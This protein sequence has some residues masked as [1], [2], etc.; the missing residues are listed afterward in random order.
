M[1][2]KTQ[3]LVHFIEN[4]PQAFLLH[5]VEFSPRRRRGELCFVERPAHWRH[6]GTNNSWPRTKV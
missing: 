2:S 5:I 3:D 4:F 1:R 6:V